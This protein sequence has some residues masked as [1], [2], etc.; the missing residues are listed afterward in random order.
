MLPGQ[1]GAIIEE[2]V[3]YTGGAQSC[4]LKHENK[5]GRESDILC[6]SQMRFQKSEGYK[7]FERRRYIGERVRM[8]S[9]CIGGVNASGV[10][11]M[12]AERCQGCARGREMC[13]QVSRDS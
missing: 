5:N 7:W 1:W 11:S 6:N 2:A 4:A 8:K 13:E 9:A 3:K 12:G 10:E